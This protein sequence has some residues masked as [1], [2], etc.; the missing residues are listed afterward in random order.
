MLGT[1]QC[2]YQDGANVENLRGERFSAGRQRQNTTVAYSIR[3][4]YLAQLCGRGV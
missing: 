4:I 1:A 2:I 3:C